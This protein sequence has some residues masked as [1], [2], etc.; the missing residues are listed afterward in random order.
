MRFSLVKVSLLSLSLFLFCLRVIPLSADTVLLKN[1]NQ[2]RGIVVKEDQNKVVLQFDRDA[3]VEF[4]RDEVEKIVYDS[5]KEKG[6]IRSE[7]ERKAETPTE[8]SIPSV[9]SP[10]E[11]VAP[12]P[13]EV[14]HPILFAPR[15]TGKE[16]EFLLPEGTWQARKTQHFIVYHQ[17]P[18]QGK[19][20]ANRAEY[21]L[22]KIV[23]D[24]R[25]RKAHDATKKYTVVI[26]KEKSK[27]EEFLK[28]LGIQSE[29]TGGFA[30][31][32]MKREI[33]LHS[34]SIPYLQLAFPHELTHIIAD[35]MANGR[36]F[37]LWFDE[38]FANYE[39]GII[40]LDE[41]L[42]AEALQKGKLIPLAELVQSK[43][44][45]SDVDRRKLFYTEAER[46]VEFLITQYGRRRFGEF[47]ETLL[48]TGDFEQAIRFAYGGKIGSLEELSRLWLKYLSE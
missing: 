47:T 37:P 20:I 15:S 30:T 32:A 12:A 23:D 35:E 43:S 24:L 4:S 46:I 21:H 2:V 22:E 1:G 38:G 36:R 34:S 41:A 14:S 29:L 13:L 39:G 6:S 11:P 25:M 3:T 27:W 5:E 17:D 8:A 9:E 44:Y 31:G 48:A 16:S 26:V 45:P 10:P 28:K 33:F 40:G 42:L 18:R 19:A 7:W